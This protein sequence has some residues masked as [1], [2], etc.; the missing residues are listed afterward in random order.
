MTTLNLAHSPVTPAFLSGHNRS[1]LSEMLSALATWNDARITRKELSKL[2]PREL[3][4]IGLS[5]FDVSTI[6]Q[7]R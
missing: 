6:G 7:T 3:D 4:D 2:S 5:P 1:K